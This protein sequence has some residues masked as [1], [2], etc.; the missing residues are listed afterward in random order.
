MPFFTSTERLGYLLW[1]RSDE[2]C[3]CGGNPVARV[4]VSGKAGV[5][6]AN[7]EIP[8]RAIV[9]TVSFRDREG[10][11]VGFDYAGE[12]E[13]TSLFEPIDPRCTHPKGA[14]IRRE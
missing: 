6:I 1:R 2:G 3:G 8:V 7:K 10:G 13:C 14:I 4:F 9:I 12:I 11:V 5:S